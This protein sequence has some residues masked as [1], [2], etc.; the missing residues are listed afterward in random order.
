M[1]YLGL[2]DFIAVVGLPS[3]DS[4]DSQAVGCSVLAEKNSTIVSARLGMQKKRTVD[5]EQNSRRVLVRSPMPPREK[6]STL[7]SGTGTLPIT[8]NEKPIAGL[9]RTGGQRPSGK[10]V[11]ESK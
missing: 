7:T 5:Q 9:L 3:A 2:S 6:R 1:T 10:N 4:S 11:Y 8:R